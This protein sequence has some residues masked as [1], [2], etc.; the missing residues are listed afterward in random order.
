MILSISTIFLYNF[1]MLGLDK[2]QI[3]LAA[4]KFL[5]LIKKAVVPGLRGLVQFPFFSLGSRPLMIGR[6]VTI[7]YRRKIH[8]KPWVYLGAYCWINAYSSEGLMLGRRVTIR[9]FGIIQLS[10]SVTNPGVGLSIGDNVYIGPRCNIGSGGAIHIGKDTQIGSDFIVV[11][12]N[13]ALEENGIS[14]NRVSRLGVFIGEKCW[15]GH[16]VLIVDGVTLGDG[17]VV[18]AG[19][20]V[21]KSFPAKSK[22]AGIPA[23]LI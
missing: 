8:A 12:E 18:G 4:K 15:V 21:T 17:C 6:G 7:Q 19:S 11:S 23:R 14:K 20:V 3:E 9:E 5:W 1:Q 16:R 22:I 13:H 10:S 2:L